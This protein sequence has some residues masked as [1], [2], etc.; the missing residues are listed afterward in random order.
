M[1]TLYHDFG[2]I[3]VFLI[4]LQFLKSVLLLYQDFYETVILLLLFLQLK[5]IGKNEENDVL[6]LTN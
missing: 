6:E 2:E 4:F 3:D 1:L 5:R